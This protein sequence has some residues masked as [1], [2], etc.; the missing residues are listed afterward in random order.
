[1]TL[2]EAGS[3][4]TNILHSGTVMGDKLA[5]YEDTPAH[6][7]RRHVASGQVAQPGDP[8]KMTRAM[9]A[10]A[11]APNAPLRLVLGK[12]AFACI[13]AALTGRMATLDKQE[14]LACSTDFDSDVS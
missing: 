1:V 6:V 8:V 3:A 9:I 2:V 13:R 10:C 11:Q 5:A 4:R 14:V 12:D 7:A